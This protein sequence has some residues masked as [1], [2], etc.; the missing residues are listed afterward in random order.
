V[1]KTLLIVLAV[2]AVIGVAGYIY[3]KTRKLDDFEGL[4]KS[5]LQNAV[6]NGSN[7]LY[8]LEIDKLEADVLQ[9]RVLLLGV[10]LK[11]DS[12][13]LQQLD[14]QQAAPNTVLD[15]QFKQLALDGIDIAK[16]V[17][18]KSIKLDVLYLK[19]PDV[20]IRFTKRPYNKKPVADS[21]P[22]YQRIAK[23]IGYLSVQKLVIQEANV[24][25][26]NN[27]KNK[28]SAFEH[29]NLDFDNILIDSSSTKDTTRL[30]FAQNLRCQ[31]SNYRS[32]TADSLYILQF[33]TVALDAAAKSFTI[34]GFA[35]KPRGDIA[36]FKKYLKYRQD[37]YDLAAGSIVLN[38]IDWQALMEEEGFVADSAY[39]RDM[40]FNSFCDR[41]WDGDGKP[42]I[43]NYP[44]QSLLNLKAPIY[45]GHIRVSNMDIVY[46][47][48]NP[49][50]EKTGKLSFINARGLLTNVTNMP[51][52]YAANPLFIASAHAQFMGSIPLDATFTFNLAKAN[53]GNFAVDATLGA[54]D[55]TV[56]NEHAAIPLGMFEI[57][58]CQIQHLKTHINAD[59]YNSN[60]WVD[61][62][63][64]NLKISALKK[65]DSEDKVKRRGL[66]SFIANT[67]VVNKSHPEKKE[68]SSVH[69]VAFK[70][71][72][73]KSFFN[74]I[75]KTL[76][77]GITEA[78]GYKVKEKPGHVL[79]SEEEDKK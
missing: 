41:S 65:D 37:R 55:A 45:I 61:L 64:D 13:R 53:K 24:R 10:T 59:N 18:D 26:V 21:L 52:R 56:L 78:V 15:V 47:E 8:R 43:G 20:T 73:E 4:L 69:K 77:Q 9:S 44:H 79:P 50:S 66:I 54:F 1:K 68:K 48:Y 17:S 62:V 32:K 75:W 72:T 39:V 34:K 63:Y 49:N 23:D 71:Y 42:K 60:G 27:A 16:A 3:L 19:Q 38:H 67:F 57:N 11:P 40:K 36:Y 31:L 76:L 6:S 2:V 46:N 29:V 25:Y 33:D 35:L 28:T 70:R 5:K 74:L 22:L 58:S 14:A 30:L 51:E 7:G 12:V